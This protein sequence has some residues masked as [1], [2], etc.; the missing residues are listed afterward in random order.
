MGCVPFFPKK[1]FFPLFRDFL[2]RNWGWCL[3]G[4]KEKLEKITLIIIHLVFLP[5]KCKTITF[6]LIDKDYIKIDGDVP[7]KNVIK[8]LKGEKLLGYWKRIV[9]GGAETNKTIPQTSLG[10]LV[11][12]RKFGLV[13]KHSFDIVFS[14]A[15]PLKIALNPKYQTWTGHLYSSLSSK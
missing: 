4:V 15:V 10:F 5:S 13:E 6:Y 7:L 12:N 9:R 1:I 2:M 8:M 14:R 3:G 11:L